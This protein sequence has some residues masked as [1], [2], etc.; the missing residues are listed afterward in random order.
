MSNKPPR[1]P[2]ETGR[3]NRLS[4][5]TGVSVGVN[6]SFDQSARMTERVAQSFMSVGQE[7]SNEEA[8]LSAQQ[9]AI[10][11]PNQALS[12]PITQ[13]Q[14]VY[15]DTYNDIS[16]NV[17]L[18]E[19]SQR[20]SQISEDVTTY[21]ALNSDSLD[22]Y[23]E[24]SKNTIDAML[25]AAPPVIR[26]ELELA[27]TKVAFDAGRGVANQVYQYD[28]NYM[29]GEFD[30]TLRTYSENAERAF[31]TGN[32]SLAKDQIALAVYA[33]ENAAQSG[34]IKPTE[35]N[36]IITTLRDKGVVGT[37]TAEYKD[38][39]KNDSG[40]AFLKHLILNRPSFMT[41]TQYQQ[42]INSLQREGAAYRSTISNAENIS[43]LKIQEA[44]TDGTISS[45][46][47][48][49]MAFSQLFG[50]DFRTD[51]KAYKNF[52]QLYTKIGKENTQARGNTELY[53]LMLSGGNPLDVGSE[54]QIQ[55]SIVQSWKMTE[56][57]RL[58]EY[59]ETG[60]L[61]KSGYRAINASVSP[62]SVPQ[63]SSWLEFTVRQGNPDQLAQAYE[64]FKF[65]KQNHKEYLIEGGDAQTRS[66]FEKVY[67]LTNTEGVPL[68]QAVND[69]VTSIMKIDRATYKAREEDSKLITKDWDWREVTAKE[70]DVPET[71]DAVDS[72][73]VARM[74]EKVM[75]YLPIV[76]DPDLAIQM[77]AS[78]LS[79]VNGVD[80]FNK[81]DKVVYMGID[82]WFERNGVSPEFYEPATRSD[83]NRIM[84]T[85]ISDYQAEGIKLEKVPMG[86]ANIINT[87]NKYGQLYKY[88]DLYVA[89][90]IVTSAKTHFPG[91]GEK[92]PVYEL[93]F[94]DVLNKKPSDI[95]QDV[96]SGGIPFPYLPIDYKEVLK[97]QLLIEENRKVKKDLAPKLRNANKL[98]F[99]YAISP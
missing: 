1:Y 73:T 89:P 50:A 76:N 63:L 3:K 99:P 39:L 87:E 96:K 66:V 74:K 13:A 52:L 88:N 38:R 25:D 14:K 69:A 86:N 16:A 28:Q 72:V 22:R 45:K 32:V 34:L 51:P 31:G 94:Y 43:T 59:K 44:V 75:Q 83:L 36:N 21:G 85:I 29:E 37:Y 15:Y 5:N 71:M 2:K 10:S 27:L 95:I 84:D 93:Q 68:D 8:T 53:N 17:I 35:A 20:I 18:S 42:T 79:A 55:S 40:D 4:P 58:D 46:E 92:T 82:K 23:N 47:Q 60:H 56:S 81:R 77:G 54:K 7:I 6:N 97:E 30:N 78:E 70:W 91:K 62:V 64:D 98:G 12:T 11:D 26:P 90:M 9:A 24:L 65:I 41:D 57:D 67:Y 33:T 49:E 48:L 80:S 19:G 61:D